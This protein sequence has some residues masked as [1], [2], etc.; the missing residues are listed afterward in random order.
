MS[1][2]VISESDRCELGRGFDG[3][4]GWCRAGMIANFFMTMVKSGN[5]FV[6]ASLPVTPTVYANN[7]KLF[8]RAQLEPTDALSLDWMSKYTRRRFDCKVMVEKS[9]GCDH[10]TV[11]CVEQI[12]GRREILHISEP[13]DIMPDKSRMSTKYLYPEITNIMIFSYL[14]PTLWRNRPEGIEH[15]IPATAE[16]ADITDT[17]IVRRL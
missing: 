15:G 11:G 1:I 7:G 9:D 8:L 16:I 14:G 6:G 10:M 4:D 12:I 2:R 3:F 5:F 17:E 13:V